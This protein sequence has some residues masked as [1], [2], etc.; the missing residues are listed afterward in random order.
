MNPVSP[1]ST[2]AIRHPDGSIKTR[3]PLRRGPWISQQRQ[4]L[5]GRP[6]PIA[7]MRPV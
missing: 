5:P 2:V 3:P 4:L 6:T 7:V 1:I